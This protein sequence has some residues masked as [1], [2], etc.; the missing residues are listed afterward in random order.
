MSARQPL[1]GMLAYRPRHA[2]PQ[3]RWRSAMLLL[4][5]V[6]VIGVV[7]TPAGSIVFCV[8]AVVGAVIG[9][10]RS[11]WVRTAAKVEEILESELAVRETPGAAGRP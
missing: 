3:V 4:A 8:V 5:T 2:R 10:L 9:V 11:R 1:L 6:A 7:D